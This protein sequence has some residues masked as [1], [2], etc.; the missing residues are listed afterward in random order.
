MGAA[1]SW[2]CRVLSEGGQEIPIGAGP[3]VVGASPGADL[4]VNDIA[5]SRHH[6]E[7][8][9]VAEGIKIRD[10]GSTNGTYYRSSRIESVIIASDA[11][12]E[13]GNTKLEVKSR[14]RPTVAPSSRARFGGLIGESFVMREV[15]AIL[16]L[17][18]PTNAPVLI[19]GESGTGKELAA[20][21][22]HDHSLRADNPFVVVDCCATPEQLLESQLFGHRQGAFTS[23]SADRRGAFL[24]ANG[25]TLFLDE[26]GELPLASQGKLL[27]A[28]EAQTVQPLGSDKPIKVDVRVIAATN[29]NLEEMVEEKRF[30]FDLFHRLAVVYFEMPPLRDHLEDIPMLIRYF[31][32]GRGISPGEVDGDNLQ[33]L[34]QYDWPGNVR[35]LRNA[36]ERALVLAGPGGA[37]FRELFFQLG[38]AT[39]D[40]PTQSVDTTLSFKEAKEAWNDLFERRYLASVFAECAFNIS[41]AATHAGINRNH[42]RKLLA[43]HGLLK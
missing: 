2:I 10:L 1:R 23:A 39:S 14:A 18:G 36:L 33:R 27:R 26:L 17:A 3:C 37:D 15:F 9:L 7:I 25:G 19:E 28:L 34:R 13:I 24:E 30:R 16:A 6:A 35:E 31:Y 5:V 12:V 20:R 21:A 29:R 40:I 22:I 41:K 8:Q 43:K 32:E 42:F 11:I 38:R 4:V